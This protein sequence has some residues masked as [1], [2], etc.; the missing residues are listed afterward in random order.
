LYALP[1]II[2]VIKSRRMRWTGR[3]SH[4]GDV[5]NSY[6]SLV[7]KPKRTGPRYITLFCALLLGQEIP[8]HTHVKHI[9]FMFVYFNVT[10]LR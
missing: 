9:N 4:M 10:V 5:K 6:E 7:R 1:N 8:F 2:N 3:V